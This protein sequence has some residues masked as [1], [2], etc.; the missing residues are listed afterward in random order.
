M[1][2]SADF[3][4]GNQ[5]QKQYDAGLSI[6]HRGASNVQAA[7][8]WLKSYAATLLTLLAMHHIDDWYVL[9]RI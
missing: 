5:V 3:H 8:D 2:S 9:S 6:D 7:L 1:H 4:W